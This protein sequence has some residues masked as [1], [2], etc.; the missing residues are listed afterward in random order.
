MVNLFR[1]EWRKVFANFRL[2][3]FL[4]W[5]FPIG[6]FAFYAVM[7][8]FS[9]FSEPMQAGVEYFGSGDWTVD[10]LATWDMMITFPSNLFAR[11]LPLA[12][13][14]VVFAGEYGW[15]TW[16][17]V[18]PRTER[19][20]LI[21]AKMAALVSLVMLSLILTALVSAVGPLTGH[22]IHGLLYEPAFSLPVLWRFLFDTAKLAL[23]S[24]LSLTILAGYAGI[25]AITTRSILG[26]LMVGFGFSVLDAVS[27]GMLGLLGTVLNRPSL[28]NLYQFTPTYNLGNMQSWLMHGEALQTLTAGLA[29]LSTTPG[30]WLSAAIIAGWFVILI[31]GSLLLFQ[32]QELTE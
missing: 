25:A 15:R 27:L 3:S 10:S 30:F 14:A 29:P 1:A 21:L 24:L 31:G 4:V 18:V 13:M 8:L 19:W 6:F 2:N 9:L 20:K 22:R 7:I 23:I 32:R 11:M 12:F 5:I 26:G 28:I 16:K 17:N